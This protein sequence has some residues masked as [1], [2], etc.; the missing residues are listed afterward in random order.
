VH[1][2]VL[3]GEI[4]HRRF[5][6]LARATA[7]PTCRPEQ[8]PQAPSVEECEESPAAEGGRPPEAL[9]APATAV[10]PQWASR[11]SRRR[12]S[13]N[14]R[15]LSRRPSASSSLRYAKRH[16][17]D[18]NGPPL[19]LCAGPTTSESRQRIRKPSYDRT[20]LRRCRRR[21]G[22]H[23]RTRRDR[24]AA[25]NTSRA[26]TRAQSRASPSIGRHLRPVTL[27]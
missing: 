7:A 17:S 24:S 13:R 1:C 6:S 11:R 27:V 23:I 16:R 15:V 25:S 10:D 5:A 8:S 9:L 18:P 14:K 21:H 2:N 3:P 12:R 4:A 26:A 19:I 22:Q 20:P